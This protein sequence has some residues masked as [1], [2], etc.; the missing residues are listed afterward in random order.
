MTGAL[1]VERKELA[2][3]TRANNRLITRL[4]TTKSARAKAAFPAAAATV[5]LRLDGVGLLLALLLV[6]CCLPASLRAQDVITTIAGN[7]GGENVAGASFNLPT[8]VA[9]D[10]LGDLYV[11]DANNCVVWEISNGVSTVIAGIQGNCTPGAGFRRTAIAGA[12]HR[13]GLLRQQSLLRHAR[14]RSAAF[15]AEPFNGDRRRR[16]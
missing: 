13:R 12:S 11:A 7:V 4:I 1:S 9:V 5:S 14:L 3:E 10:S 8:G 2:V 6:T 15:R 16:L